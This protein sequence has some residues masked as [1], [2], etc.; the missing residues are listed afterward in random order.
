MSAIAGVLCAGGCGA[1]VD[2]PDVPPEQARWAGFIRPRCG[3]CI[4]RERAEEQQRAV[5]RERARQQE[6]RARRIARAGCPSHLRGYSFGDIDQPDGLE[7]AMT[8]AR[9]WVAGEL[10]GLGLRGSVGVGKTRVGI[11]AAHAMCEHRAVRWYSTPALFYL[12]G[13]DYSD[14]ARKAALADL[15]SDRALVLDDVTMVRPTEYAAEML[16]LAIDQRCDGGAP[17]LVTTN[18]TGR[19]IAQRWPQPAG[20]LIASRL[21]L[22]SWVRVGGEDKRTGGRG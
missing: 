18:L 8:R 12:L 5:A 7:Q 9:A 16:F 3:G 13:S 6:T 17:L 14:K 15:S 2:A 21:A 1:M 11:A 19:E 20:E 10:N 22:L 4:E